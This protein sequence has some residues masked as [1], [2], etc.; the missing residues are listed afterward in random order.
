MTPSLMV[1]T[2]YARCLSYAGSYAER[3]SQPSSLSKSD[4]YTVSSEYSCICGIMNMAFVSCYDDAVILLSVAD[5]DL[6]F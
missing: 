2:Y 6:L 4:G 1:S 5:G 3:P